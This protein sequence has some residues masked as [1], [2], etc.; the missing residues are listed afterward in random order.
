MLSVELTFISLHMCS[1]LLHSSLYVLNDVPISTLH[2]PSNNKR[3][4]M[5]R[6]S[7]CVV[8]FNDHNVKP[9]FISFRNGAIES[10]C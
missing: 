9:F 8:F 5:S 6:K 7:K 2:F 4:V 1:A 10:E 3:I